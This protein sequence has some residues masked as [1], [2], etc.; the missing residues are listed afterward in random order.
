M[1]RTI[2]EIINENNECQ[3]LYDRTIMEIGLLFANYSRTQDEK[4]KISLD[5]KVEA[6]Q[7]V[8]VRLRELEKELTVTTQ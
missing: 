5:S 2:T 7:R 3:T 1:A 4:I 6:L 8:E